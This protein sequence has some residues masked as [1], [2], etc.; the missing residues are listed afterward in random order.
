[1]QLLNFILLREATMKKKNIN[2]AECIDNTLRKIL[3][4][5]LRDI[6]DLNMP[7]GEAQ[8]ARSSWIQPS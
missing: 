1:M 7:E 8:L 3:E 2:A 4:K 6:N 5:S